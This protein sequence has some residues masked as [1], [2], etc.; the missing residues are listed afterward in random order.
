MVHYVIEAVDKGEPIASNK[1]TI[2]DCESEDD[3]YHK[4]NIIEKKTVIDALDIM[5]ETLFFNL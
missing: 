5:I 4:M 1:L 3:Y 2:S